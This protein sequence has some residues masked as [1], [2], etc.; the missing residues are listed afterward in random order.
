MSD[1]SL[2]NILVVDDEPLVLRLHLRVLANLG[3]TAVTLCEG[4]TRALDAMSVADRLPD[5]ILLDLNMP[6]IDGVEFLRHLVK[7]D[8]RG[9]VIL[10]SG[11]DERVLQAAAKLVQAHQLTSLGHLRKPVKPEMLAALL[12]RWKPV[13]HRIASATR[14][15]YSADEV[16]A[17]IANGELVNYY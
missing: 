7:R 2:I 6:E 16:R 17:A 12:D 8:Y 10:V 4:A 9:S 14:K 11:E 5:L 13:A 15:T 1:R 3:C